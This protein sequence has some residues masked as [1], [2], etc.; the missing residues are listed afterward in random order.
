M[1]IDDQ[2]AQARREADVCM[3]R[4]LGTVCPAVVGVRKTA[5]LLEQASHNLNADQERELVD[6]VATAQE[7]HDWSHLRRV[8][9]GT[10]DERLASDY[11]QA[12]AEGQ[13]DAFR[14]ALALVRAYKGGVLL[15]ELQATM[16][17]GDVAVK[18]VERVRR[19][20][21]LRVWQAVC[22][23]SVDEP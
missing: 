3:A 6:A 23:E 16:R 14:L 11:R 21:A 10:A 22:V 8:V 9:A 17:A 1:Y 4:G 2:M 18:P 20:Q 15:T 5:Q 13:A 19:E 12:F 7:V